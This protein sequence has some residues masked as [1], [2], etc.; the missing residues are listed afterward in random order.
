MDNYEIIKILTSDQV[1]CRNWKRFC[2]ELGL[3]SELYDFERRF[4]SYEPI[5]EIYT[6][7]IEK[8]ET[9][10]SGNNEV[11]I[12]DLTEILEKLGYNMCVGKSW[13]NMYIRQRKE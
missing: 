9:G 11:R 13:P 4:N 7:M 10:N 6:L 12:T 5:E 2:R 3:G 8:W 1:L